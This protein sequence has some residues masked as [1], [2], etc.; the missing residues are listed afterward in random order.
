[1]NEY[2]TIK[3]EL[4]LDGLRERIVSTTMDHVGPIVLETDTVWT[5]DCQ[6]NDVSKVMEAAKAIFDEPM[7]KHVTIYWNWT[8]P[9]YDEDMIDII[10]HD[11]KLRGETPLDIKE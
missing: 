9:E 1:M 5:V 4:D 10:W 11:G 3:I 6:P 2:Y 7:V 8:D